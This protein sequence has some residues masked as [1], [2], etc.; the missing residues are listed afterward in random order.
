[1]RPIFAGGA[2]YSADLHGIRRLEEVHQSLR[3]KLK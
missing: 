1:M 3:V 2:V